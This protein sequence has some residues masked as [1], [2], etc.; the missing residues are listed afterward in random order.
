MKFSTLKN[1]WRWLLLA[2]LFLLA[3]CAATTSTRTA[4]P[5]E[6]IEQDPLFWQMWGSG[7]GLGG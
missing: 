3:A 1:F 5:E 4:T 7:R 6:K 2:G